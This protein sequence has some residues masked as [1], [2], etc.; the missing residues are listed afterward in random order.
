MTKFEKQQKIDKLLENFI[1]ILP[2]EDDVGESRN[3]KTLNEEIVNLAIN[4]CNTINE[5]LDEEYFMPRYYT[6]SNRLIDKESARTETFDVS[7]RIRNLIHKSINFLNTLNEN[8]PYTKENESLAQYCL[9]PNFKH[10]VDEFYSSVLHE[11]IIYES[12]ILSKNA[13]LATNDIKKFSSM[14]DDNKEYI[15]GI[16][17]QVND[18]VSEF[19]T[20]VKSKLIEAH[21]AID[22][23]IETI[24]KDVDDRLNKADKQLEEAKN[25]LNETKNIL[26]NMLTTLGIF[27]AIIIAIVAVYLSIVLHNQSNTLVSIIFIKDSVWA[28]AIFIL[29]LGVM[30]FDMLFVFLFWI[31]KLSG[32]SI[33][34]SCINGDTCVDCKKKTLCNPF[35]RV[36]KRYWSFIVFNIIILSLVTLC[37]ILHWNSLSPEE[38]KQFISNEHIENTPS[39]TPAD[40]TTSDSP[41]TITIDTPAT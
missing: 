4:V 23:K 22:N 11:I 3:E 34:C 32:R 18:N 17:Q 26:P 20:N 9:D 12:Y 39:P 6:L 40:I 10:Y 16:S 27:V 14:L 8:H 21:N 1:S 37:G 13:M 30:V 2:Y 19:N 25:N 36:W 33:G 24:N 7:S 41:I 28:R 38:Q 31:S 35:V 15:Q 29:L 5:V